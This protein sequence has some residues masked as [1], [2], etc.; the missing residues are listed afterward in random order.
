M[1]TRIYHSLI[2]QLDSSI[3]LLRWDWA[4]PS[5]TRGLYAAFSHLLQYS[6]QQQITSWL[7]DT[8]RLPL[9]TAEEQA[10]LS[11]VWLPQLMTLTIQRVALVLPNNLHNQLVLE[12]IL[13][14]RHQPLHLDLQ[15]FSDVA[16]ALDWLTPS[17]L[18]AERLEV[19]WQQAL[20]S[21][22]NRDSVC[23]MIENKH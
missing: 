15:F 12:N 1:T 17:A 9:A 11:E 16:A 20:L 14:D 13:F 19:N 2:T 4:G 3:G 6:Q 18:V 21:W 22:E 8:T 10:W 5:R 7:V 23:E